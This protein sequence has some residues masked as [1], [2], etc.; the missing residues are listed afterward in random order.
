MHTG[1]IAASGAHGYIGHAF[2]PSPSHEDPDSSEAEYV[3]EFGGNT[4]H[5]KSV[6]L[7]MCMGL[8]MMKPSYGVG[9]SED[10]G[11]S[12]GIRNVVFLDSVGEGNASAKRKVPES[13]RAAGRR[14]PLKRRRVGPA[15]Q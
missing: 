11:R 14:L 4:M 13:R 7:A 8:A 3:A 12:E 9:M 10:V 2:L 1:R 15:R 5:L 6:G